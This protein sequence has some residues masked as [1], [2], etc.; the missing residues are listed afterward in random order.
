MK[1]NYRQTVVPAAMCDF[2]TDVLL[3]AVLSVV[4]VQM[5]CI[6]IRLRC[7]KTHATG[8][9]LDS[10][11]E[12]NDNAFVSPI[13]NKIS[14]TSAIFP[15]SHNKRNI[16]LSF[17]K[18]PEYL[19]VLTVSCHPKQSQSNLGHYHLPLAPPPPP[20]LQAQI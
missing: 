3:R 10:G 2:L 8:I 16:P 19:D 6:H 9:A 12:F 11:I 4:P 20:L 17:D 13:L 14:K 7:S 5:I 18:S 1:M 15:H